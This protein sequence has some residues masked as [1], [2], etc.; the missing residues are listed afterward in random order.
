[1]FSLST[2]VKSQNNRYRCIKNPYAVYVILLYN[3]KVGVWCAVSVHKHIR[4]VFF[5][6]TNYICF[7]QLILTPFFT[8]LT[9][10]EK[11]VRQSTLEEMKDTFKRQ[12]VT[13]SRKATLMI[14]KNGRKCKTCLDAGGHHVDIPVWYYGEFK[15]WKR[16]EGKKNSKITGHGNYIRTFTR[17]SGDHL[18]TKR[19]TR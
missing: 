15:C 17:S 10:T 16:G 19:V 13:I 18:V 5:K 8:E 7:I 6:E 9:D 4:P 3:L 11:N 2:M 12:I 1:M 14:K